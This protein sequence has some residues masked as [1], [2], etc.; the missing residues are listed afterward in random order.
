MRVILRDAARTRLNATV[1]GPPGGKARAA[2]WGAGSAGYEPF[3]TVT[4][5][6]PAKVNFAARNIPA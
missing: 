1:A 6:Q 4:L 2:G 3:W 5:P